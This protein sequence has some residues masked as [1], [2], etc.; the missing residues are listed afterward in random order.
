MPKQSNPPNQ[1]IDLN[2][3][4]KVA[5]QPTE[6]QEQIALVKWLKLNSIM[7][8]ASANGGRRDLVDAVNLKRAGVSAG[9][10]DLEIPIPFN[11]KHGLYIE[12]K[13]MRGGVV[14]LEQKE[15]LDYLNLVGYVAKVAHGCHEGIE[16]VREYLGME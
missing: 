15:W 13:R 1:V 14:S 12:M 3:Y 5:T 4:R 9:F 2:S 7:H 6:Q 16:I 11:G 8:T 10:P